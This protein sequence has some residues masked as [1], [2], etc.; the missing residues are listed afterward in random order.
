VGIPENITKVKGHSE[1]K[2]TSLAEG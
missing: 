2:S 1:A